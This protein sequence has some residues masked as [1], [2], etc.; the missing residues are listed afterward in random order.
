VSVLRGSRLR[1]PY[2]EF[3]LAQGD[4]VNLLTSAAGG[5]LARPAANG[6]GRQPATGGTGGHE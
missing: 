4:H 1:P 3:V 5:S 6:N 2:P